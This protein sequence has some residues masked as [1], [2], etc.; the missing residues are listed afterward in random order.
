MTQQRAA[1]GLVASGHIPDA[2][3]SVPAADLLSALHSRTDGL[4][5]DE[6]AATLTQVGPNTLNER[7]DV[8]IA[9]LLARQFLSPIELI[10]IGATILSGVLGDW[11]DAVIILVILL[12]SGLLGFV[13]E[14]GA[15]RAMKAL[16]AVVEVT[17]TVLRGGRR[18]AVPLGSIV[19]GDVAVVAAGDIVPGDCAVLEAN[20]LT[21]DESAL[22]GETFPVD[23]QPSV[24]PAATVLTGRTGAVFLGTHVSSG[25]GTLLV[26]RTGRSTQIAAIAARLSARPPQ[27]GFEKGMTSFGLLLG[28]LMVVLVVA[29][30]I[31]NLVLQRPLIDSALFSLALAVGLTP[32]LLP[33][34]VSISLAQGARMMARKR[35][36]VRRLDAIED[37]GSMT[38]LCS[39]KTGTMTAGEIHLDTAMRLDGTADAEVAEL[40]SLNAALQTGWRNPIDQA[41]VEGLAAPSDAV[42]VGELPYDFLRKRMSVLVRRHPGEKPVLITKGALDPVIAVCTHAATAAG[43]VPIARA[44][45]GIQK[46]FADLSSQG[47]RVLGVATRTFAG[48]RPVGIGDESKMTLVGLLC[49]ADPAKP[50]A[51]ATLAELAASGVSVRMVTG[52]NRLVAA[53]IA[54]QVGLDTTTVFSGPDIDAIGDA[55]LAIAVKNVYVFSE[56][57]PVQKERVVRAFR[58]GGAVVGYLGDGINDAPP[59]HAADIGISVDTAVP[60]AK[61]SAAIVL[62][63]KDLRVILDGVRQG[64]RTFAN[65][66]KYIYMTTSANFGNMLSMALA[67]LLLPFLPLLAGQILLIN[68][69][70]DLPATTIATDSVDDAQVRSP[71][72][73]NVRLIRNYLLAFGTLS[74]VFDL[75]TFAILH[76][77]FHAA[78]PEFRSAW[79]V[80]S[81]LTE[82]GVLFALRTRGPFYRSAPGRWVVLS[83]IAVALVAVAIPYSPLAPVLSL[84][85]IPLELLGLV[86]LVTLGYIAA[87][88]LLKRV[89]WHRSN[90]R[91]TPLAARIG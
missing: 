80:A 8:S 70:T 51:A 86:F 57:D 52:D 85:P 81:I 11:T 16:L 84:V 56:L 5:A 59:L 22:T 15:G 61:Q 9:R 14:R 28:R 65:T 91:V 71:Q 40:A 2:F 75:V 38:V 32:Q 77:G 21:V 90:A 43:L 49:F 47:F 73:W 27:T 48:D 7:D 18:V 20:G 82:V 34:I 23:K 88:E 53:H 54:E 29:I 87:T 67:A 46:R 41:I 26:V 60:V 35:V 45:V 19:P 17:V 39:D 64:R 50:D 79:F 13:Q 76:F 10:L 74:S 62:L 89:F 42:A 68:L 33:A 55:A 66:M 72:R 30:F 78:A 44:R 83:S 63:D 1:A 36:I 6:A 58:A 25:T 24:V 4:T 12:V 31:I 3:W 37:F 69:L